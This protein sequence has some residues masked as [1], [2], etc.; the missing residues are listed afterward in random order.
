M[1]KMANIFNWRQWLMLYCALSFA[2]LGVDAA[3]N[4]H[5]V[6]RENVLAY[7]PLIFAPLALCYSLLGI[8]KEAFRRQAW[9]IGILALLVGGAGTVIHNYFNIIERGNQSL[10]HALLEAPLPVFAPAAFASTALLLMLISWGE[11][12]QVNGN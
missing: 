10:W 8:F 9:I 11:H 1:G 6:L 5:S 12:Q 4:H 3:M 2:L 7:T